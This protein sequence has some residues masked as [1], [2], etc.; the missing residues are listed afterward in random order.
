MYQ[1]KK[2]IIINSTPKKVWEVFS[3]IEKW[4]ELCSY[5]SKAYWNTPE[6]WALDSSFT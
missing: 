2:E 6:K 1:I 5:I 4:P 3:K